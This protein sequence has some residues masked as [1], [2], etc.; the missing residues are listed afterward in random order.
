VARPTANDVAYEETSRADW[1]P[2]FAA[3]TWV[4]GQLGGGDF[5]GVCPRCEHPMSVPVSEYVLDPTVKPDPGVFK[6]ALLAPD[7]GRG[8]DG[9]LAKCNCTYDHAGRPKDLTRGCGA[10]GALLVEV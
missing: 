4:T 3:F 2:A 6:L 1:A 10:R 9:V 8:P 7:G 5:T